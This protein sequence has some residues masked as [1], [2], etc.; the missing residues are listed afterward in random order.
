VQVS[1][2]P[3]APLQFHLFV[4]QVDLPPF[5]PSALD[6]ACDLEQVADGE[7]QCRILAQSSDLYRDATPNI[8][9]VL[10]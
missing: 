3:V 10:L 7:D 1:T 5:H 4:V 8:F 2:S 6:V 9:A